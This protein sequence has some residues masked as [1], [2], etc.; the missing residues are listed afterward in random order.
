ML[1]PDKPG[2]GK[3]TRKNAT[4]GGFYPG[5]VTNR[6]RN[7]W[8]VVVMAEGAEQLIAEAR[9][10]DQAILGRLLESY[11]NYIRL[12]ARIQIGRQLQ[13]KVD[14]SD[15]VQETF[16]DANRYFA[17]FRGQAEEQFV[18]WLREILAGTLANITRHYFGTQ[19]RDVRLECALLADLDQSS[20]AL[21][22]IIVDPRHR[23]SSVAQGVGV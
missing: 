9:A 8:K 20:N 21:A 3:V 14:A 6:D 10:G 22:Q 1:R 5:P 7:E 15:V 11:R 17:N 13:G 23:S 12:L 2:G 18:C 4:P 19:A 16:L